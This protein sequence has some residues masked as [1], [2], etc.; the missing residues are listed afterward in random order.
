MHWEYETEVS[1]WPTTVKQLLGKQK[2]IPALFEFL[3]T[4]TLGE[5][6]QVQDQEQQK[7]RRWRDKTWRLGQDSMEEK[8]KMRDDEETREK[9]SDGGEET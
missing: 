4:T 6:P 9:W 1:S 2:V 7:R 5:R 3:T 8:E